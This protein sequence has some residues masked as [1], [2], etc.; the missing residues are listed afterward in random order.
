MLQQGETGEVAKNIRLRLHIVIFGVGLID[1]RFCPVC[2]VP[3]F[4]FAE[5]SIMKKLLIMTVVAMISAGALGCHRVRSWCNPV[6][7]CAP[8]CPA[9][10]ACNPCDTAPVYDDSYLAPP[11]V[12]VY[13]PEYAPTPEMPG[14]TN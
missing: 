8:S 7:S 1:P 12:D 2:I 14:P 3:V 9:P 4:H 5:M 6:T 11:S 13:T 10:P